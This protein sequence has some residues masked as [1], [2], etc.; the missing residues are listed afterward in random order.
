MIKN[1][2]YYHT[3]SHE[4]KKVYTNLDELPSEYVRIKFLYCGI[5]GGDYSYYV[6]RRTDYPVSLGHEWIGEI[7]SVGNSVKMLKEGMYVVTDLNYRCGQ[8]DYCKNG[9]SHLCRKNN[10]SL[11]SNRGFA[12]Y[13]NIH[14]SYLYPI[15][16]LEWL[17]RACL[18]EPL[19]CVL[20][21][22]QKLEICPN[23]PLL[24]CGGG[25]IGMLMCFYL[26]RV[27]HCSQIYVAEKN[28]IRLNNL[29][30]HFSVKKFDINKNIAFDS[31]IDCT[32]SISGAMLALNMVK[33]GGDICIM[34]H[35]YGLETSFIYENICKKELNAS[36]PLRNGNFN[37]LN[38][39]IEL[40]QKL[41]TIDDDCMIKIYN[42]I[43]LAFE[44]K[45]FCSCNKQVIS[46]N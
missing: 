18:I 5:C 32:N 42:D 27:M 37:N 6:G 22:L 2:V 30:E 25:S 24:L 10:I 15:S 39:A 33:P 35:L 17:P 45:E 9:Q 34:S 3:A 20:H 43:E 36:F 23:V 46:L 14:Y 19:S 12:K 11:F 28:I 16:N 26:V 38:T 7:I 40:V 1:T 21:A 4:I 29:I 41:W 13:A 31:V 44:E 8:C